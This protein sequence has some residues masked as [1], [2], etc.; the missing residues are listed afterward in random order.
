MCGDL[1]HPNAF[2]EITCHRLVCHCPGI[3]CWRDAR[4]GRTKLWTWRSLG[5]DRTD[6]GFWLLQ[7]KTSERPFRLC[8]WLSLRRP[9]SLRS[10]WS[11]VD[12]PQTCELGALLRATQQ[13][14]QCQLRRS[15]RRPDQTEVVTW[16]PATGH[17]FCGSNLDADTVDRSPKN[18]PN[19]SPTTDRSEESINHESLIICNNLKQP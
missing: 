7:A 8:H 15:E 10:Q 2:T 9:R 17:H 1:G 3:H 4:P 6:A 13:I 5:S 14:R 12:G 18:G 16:N 19:Q 11:L